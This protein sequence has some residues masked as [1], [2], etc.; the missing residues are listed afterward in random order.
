MHEGRLRNEKRQDL[1]Q[2]KRPAQDE[3]RESPL[4][5]RQN[6]QQTQNC[7]ARISSRRQFGKGRKKNGCRSADDDRRNRRSQTSRQRDGS[8]R[9]GF[10]FLGHASFNKW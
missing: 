5:T 6:I 9:S 3:S 2:Q 8:H 7:F 10:S 4:E 1:R